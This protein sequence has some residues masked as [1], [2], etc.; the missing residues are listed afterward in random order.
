MIG[1]T[2]FFQSNYAE[3][4]SNIKFIDEYSLSIRILEIKDWQLKINREIND[5]DKIMK[6]EFDFYMNDNV[7]IYKKLKSNY[8][9]MNNSFTMID[10]ITQIFLPLYNDFNESV[11]DSLESI[12]NDT[13]VS[14]K[15]LF[16]S[17]FKEYRKYQKKYYRS[18]RKLKKAFKKDKKKL[19]FI[20]DFY[21][22]YRNIYFDL[23]FKRE[24]L[25]PN[26]DIFYRKLNQAVFHDVGS[27]DSKKI[28]YI[29]VK[30]EQYISGLDKYE[31]FLLNID[32]VSYKEKN[33]H[34]VLLAKKESMMFM[35]R[36]EKGT[37]E[38]LK[39]LKAIRKMI[40]I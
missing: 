28:K 40:D 25:N 15:R 37:K 23:K 5:L 31:K 32:K 36:F 29:S 10:S 27:S 16:K 1:G 4:Y 8:N 26:I 19:V 6:K 7:R 34:V 33:S 35:N 20:A 3:N 14:Y 21:D 12:P 9:K 39:S 38:Y 24:N 17:Y 18:L 22:S 30:L 13:T 11:S 2:L